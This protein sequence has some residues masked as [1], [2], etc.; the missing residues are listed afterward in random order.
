MIRRPPRSTLFPYTTLFR[1]SQPLFKPPDDEGALDLLPDSAGEQNHGH[2][3][4]QIPRA[5]HQL[6]QDVLFAAVKTRQQVAEARLEEIEPEENQGDQKESPRHFPPDGPPRPEEEGHRGLSAEA[7]K[8][9]Q[10][11]QQKAGGERGDACEGYHRP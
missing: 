1:S 11:G 3:K 2:E 7:Q 4:S 8:D 9:P 10:Q 6:L 5:S